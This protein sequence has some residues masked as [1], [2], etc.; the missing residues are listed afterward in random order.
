MARAVGKPRAASSQRQPSPAASGCPIAGLHGGA[1]QLQYAV[2][3]QVRRWCVHVS[4]LP[5]TV[6]HTC[7][8]LRAWWSGLCPT[9]H[10]HSRSQPY[11]RSDRAP[12]LQDTRKHPTC[13][14]Y[15]LDKRCH[16][17]RSGRCPT[18]GQCIARMR[19]LCR[20]GA[21]LQAED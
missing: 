13:S 15:Q 19:R 14:R 7:F 17:H 3:V 18:A 10:K 4:S 21:G 11:P 1:A 20:T 6:D 2:S 16:S 8:P 5:L 9:C 12:H